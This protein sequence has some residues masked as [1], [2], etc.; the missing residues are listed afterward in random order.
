[1][2]F[3]MFEFWRVTSFQWLMINP[4]KTILNH[5]FLVISSVHRGS[6]GN[7]LNE[8]NKSTV[9]HELNLNV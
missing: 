5:K 1:M 6:I 4:S 2:D 8:K 7:T 3:A 9:A